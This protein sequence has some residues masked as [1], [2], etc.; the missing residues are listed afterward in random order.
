MNNPFKHRKEYRT[1]YRLLFYILII[2][3]IF[4]LIGTC[5][6]LYLDYSRDMKKINEG[7]QHIEQGYLQSITGNLWALDRGQ[8]KINFK[9][10]KNDFYQ[11]S[12][13]DNG[14]GLPETIEINNSDT[15]GLEL[16]NILTDQINGV[17]KIQRGAGTEFEITFPNSGD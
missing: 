7:I 16:V 10:V 5:V 14:V 3:S 11:L 4:T 1:S 15:L 17:I 2:S 13:K 8:I 9:T 6:Q 12:V